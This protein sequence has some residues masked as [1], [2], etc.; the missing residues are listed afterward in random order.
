MNG[1]AIHQDQRCG[2]ALPEDGFLKG[3]IFLIAFAIATFQSACY[4]RAAQPSTT[5]ACY[6]PDSYTAGQIAQLVSITAATDPKI[7][8]WRKA[9]GLPAVP[10]SAI[11]L[12]SDSTTC[13]RGLRALNRT[14]GYHGV[15]AAR[16]YLIRVGP[17]YVASNPNF[18]GGEWT[19]QF[20]FDSTFK[21]KFS[22][23]H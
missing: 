17:M 21:Y 1:Q 14:A 7:V 4:P 2:K 8:A 5:P 19:Q 10:A 12:V 18:P 20:V 6:A 13:A 23:L 9:V 22:Y 15:P 3:I 11:A 16:L